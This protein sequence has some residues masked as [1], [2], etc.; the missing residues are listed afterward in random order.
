MLDNQL[1]GNW[2]EQFIAE[3]LSANNCFVRQVTQGQDS[4][5]DLY[6]EK[7]SPDKDNSNNFI[8]FLHFWCQVKTR[9]DLKGRRKIIC[10]PNSTERKNI[11]IDYWIKQPVPVFIFIIPDFRNAENKFPYYIF[12]TVNFCFQN[13]SI[14]SSYKIHPEYP[15]KKFLDEDLL[16]E[17]YK[18]ELMNGKV[19][20][21][22]DP[23]FEYAIKFPK[24][25]S[26]N[27]EKILRQS[28][29]WKLHR[30]SSDILYICINYKKNGEGYEKLYK[31]GKMYTNV[32]EK[33]V[34]TVNDNHFH[35]FEII[36]NYFEFENNFIDAKK[37]YQI[38]LRHLN[39]DQLIDKNEEIW[40]EAIDRIKANIK[41]LNQPAIY[42][43]SDF[44]SAFSECF[45]NQEVAT[46][47]IAINTKI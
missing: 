43:S 30:L 20:A 17:T 38:A 42:N 24:G 34:N 21:L 23:N 26:S 4:G 12:N 25:Y 11:K 9:K 37:Y 15:L 39:N 40:D 7:L 31:K 10:F 14:K 22:K 6:C 29:L 46:T 18:W 45:K 33:L 41:R 35:N 13:N 5:I 8:P 47:T 44:S 1:Q 19:S 32:L 28:L 36:G 2:G 3:Q 16:I 27:F